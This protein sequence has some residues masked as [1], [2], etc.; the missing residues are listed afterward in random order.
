MKK[1]I[2]ALNAKG[3]D[4][5]KQAMSNLQREAVI[6]KLK[7]NTELRNWAVWL[8]DIVLKRINEKVGLQF[9]KFSF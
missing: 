5:L 6:S 3:N 4:R 2:V 8:K 9:P 1:A 7:I